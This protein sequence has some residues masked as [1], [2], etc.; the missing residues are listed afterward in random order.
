M[1]QIY[2]CRSKQYKFFYNFSFLCAE[3]WACASYLFSVKEIPL[4]QLEKYTARAESYTGSA[5]SMP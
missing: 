3:I 4:M 5:D 1:L 2:L